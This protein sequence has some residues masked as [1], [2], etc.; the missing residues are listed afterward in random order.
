M[1]A[2]HHETGSTEEHTS[3]LQHLNNPNWR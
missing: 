1:T 2:L 3:I